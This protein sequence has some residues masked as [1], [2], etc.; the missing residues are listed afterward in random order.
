VIPYLLLTA[1]L[2]GSAGF[3]IG[4]RVRPIPRPVW[5]CARCDDTALTADEQA[6]FKAI[7]AYFDPDDP[8]SNAA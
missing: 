1:T 8:R 7:E 6:A 2:A 4:Y 3:T 5:A